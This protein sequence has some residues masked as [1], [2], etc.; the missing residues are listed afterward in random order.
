MFTEKQ[1]EFIWEIWHG[2]PRR[3]RVQEW[4]SE[5]EA[6]ISAPR[7]NGKG[8]VVYGIVLS[9]TEWYHLSEEA[10]IA[11]FYKEELESLQEETEELEKRKERVA[12]L[13]AR[14]ESLETFKE[15]LRSDDARTQD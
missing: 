15:Y 1:P 6:I 9:D 11:Q 5:V 8:Y 13:E 4:T 12:V 3:L 2:Q 7:S 10:C 14:L